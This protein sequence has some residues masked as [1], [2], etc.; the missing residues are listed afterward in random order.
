MVVGRTVTVGTT[1]T[2]LSTAA[3]A[4]G[5]YRLLVRSGGQIWIGDSTV[6]PND[7]WTLNSGQTLDITLQANDEVYAIAGGNTSVDVLAMTT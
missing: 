2:N 6:A 7:G 5:E 4:E 1:A 3:S